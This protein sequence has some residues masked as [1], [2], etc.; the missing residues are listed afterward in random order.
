VG[1]LDRELLRRKAHS[2]STSVGACDVLI[3]ANER[4]PR[5]RPGNSQPSPFDKLRA[6]SS[7]LL[8]SPLL[9]RTAPDFLHAALDIFACAAFFTESRMRLILS[10]NLDRKFGYVLGYFQQLSAAPA[11][12]KGSSYSGASGGTKNQKSQALPMTKRA[13]SVCSPLKPKNGLNGPP[14]ALVAGAESLHP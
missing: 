12:L 2:R 6:G 7:G 9:P 13:G 10:T 5:L 8:R 3:F 14:K 11:G 4:G 1:A